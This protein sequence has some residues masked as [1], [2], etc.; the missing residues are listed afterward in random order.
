[1]SMAVNHRVVLL[2]RQLILLGL[3]LS[4]AACHESRHLAAGQTLYTANV[5]K[6]QSSVPLSHRRTK[7]LKTDL[8]Q[9]LRPNL[10]G[11]ILG[12]RAKLWVYNIAGTSKKKKGFKHWLKYEVGEPP[13]LS[14]PKVIEKNREILQNHLENKGYFGDTV[15]STT[16]VK[17]KHL[18]AVY[19]AQ[20]GAPYTI[21]NVSFPPD[22]DDLSLRIDSLQHGT[23]LKKGD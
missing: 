7:E 23:L 14:S 19:T 4:E 5:V 8:A 9:L 15:L 13:V 6:N 16:P 22:S 12:I 2:I 21:R 18:T 11:K 17:D 1:M 3:V 20:I 10:N